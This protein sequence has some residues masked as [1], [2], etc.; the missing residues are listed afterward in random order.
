[1]AKVH[2]R[3]TAQ[4][5]KQASKRTHRKCRSAPSVPTNVAVTFHKRD[6]TSRVIWKGRVTW[7]PVTTDIAGRDLEPDAY[8]VQFRACDASGVPVE[9]VDL[10][11]E[12]VRANEDTR[13]VFSPLPRPKLWYYQARVAVFHRHAGVRCFSAWTD[14]TTPEQP[15]TGALP[16]PAAPD[17]LALTFDRV[18]GVKGNGWRA[19]AVWNETPTWTPADGD[20]VEG[21]ETYAVQLRV[22]NNGGSTVANKRSPIRVDA[23]PSSPTA[24]AHFGT[25]IRLRRHYSFRVRAIDI[26]GRQGAWSDWSAWSAPVGT[27]APP[28]NVTV[29]NPVPR[30]IVVRWDPPSDLTDIDYYLVDIIRTGGG[31]TLVERGRTAGTKYVYDVPKADRGVNHRARVKSV[32]TPISLDEES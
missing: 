29:S 26:F 19:K 22:S 9:D 16:G 27:L 3:G 6:I 28:E 12:M 24:F 1:M 7:D 8:M 2:R 11:R 13:A 18:E 5:A 15:A 25:N 14:W 20:T 32:S 30:R 21:A 31:G 10:W 17:G 23:D 4:R